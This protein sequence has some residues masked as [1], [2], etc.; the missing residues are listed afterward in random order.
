MKA[1][2]SNSEHMLVNLAED[3]L[4]DCKEVRIGVHPFNQSLPLMKPGC[5]AGSSMIQLLLSVAF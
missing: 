4:W 5:A 2:F 1:A 3:R